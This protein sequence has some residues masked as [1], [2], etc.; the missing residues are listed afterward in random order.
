LARHTSPWP[1]DT[2]QN[3]KEHCSAKLL[4]EIKGQTRVQ[5]ETKGSGFNVH[6]AYRK[7]D[8]NP[9]L[10]ITLSDGRR[11]EKFI[12]DLPAPLGRTQDIAWPNRGKPLTVSLEAAEGIELSSFQ[13][14]EFKW[15]SKSLVYVRPAGTSAL[16]ESIG[17][18]DEAEAEFEESDVD[19][20]IEGTGV[21]GLPK[22]AKIYVHNPD[23]DYV[24]GTYLPPGDNPLKAINGKYY[25]EERYSN[26]NTTKSVQAV[27]G[28]WLEVDLTQES[29][30]DLF[31]YYSHRN[32][33]SELVQ[34]IGF[35]SNDNE[36]ERG[37]ALAINNDQFFRLL[38][39]PGCVSQKIQMNLGEVRH[40]YGASEIEVY[41][42]K[43]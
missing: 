18:G 31:A 38:Y 10:S 21:S 4:K 35:M 14:W 8:S 22:D 5:A 29:K 6:L 28:L 33:Q 17:L 24:A 20:D 3:L 34:N 39:T 12:L 9:L 36:K 37:F 1:V 15:P 26:W 32:K 40:S 41:K 27:R 16:A 30:F 42:A 19:D 13:I 2:L 7:P 23:P 11:K 25:S 43:E